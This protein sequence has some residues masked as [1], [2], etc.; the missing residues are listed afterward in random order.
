MCSRKQ[1]IMK[2]LA[3]NDSPELQALHSWNNE[4]KKGNSKVLLI[5]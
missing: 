4:I 5:L 2:L 3:I 1:L